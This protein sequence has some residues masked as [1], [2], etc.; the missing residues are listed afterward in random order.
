MELQSLE[1]KVSALFESKFNQQPQLI[2]SAPG[3]INIIGEHTDYNLGLSMPAAINRWV[4]V[5]FAWRNDNIVKVASESY[6]NEMVYTIGQSFTPSDSW[7]KF[8]YG[9]LEIFQRTNKMDKGFNAFVWGNVPLGAGVSSS[10]A[11]EVSFMNLLRM[12]YKSP[13]TDV[14]A[15]KNCQKIEHEYIGV[16]SGLLDQYASL[17]SKA[18]KLMKLDFNSLTHEYSDADM[19]NWCWV[20]ANTK[21]K[22]ELSGSKYTERVNETQEGLKWLTTNNPKIKGFRDITINDVETIQNPVVK[23]RL[24]HFVLENA[25]VDL[26]AKAFAA[27]NIQEVGRILYEGHTSLQV[28]YEVS[29]D[30]LDYLV[31]LAKKF[32]GCAGARMMGG[33]FGGCTINLLKK[34]KLADFSTYILSNYKQKF[35]IDSEIYAFDVVD[36]A[37][38][39]PTT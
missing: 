20:L 9:A 21:V 2:S 38:C 10:A 31:E 35:N 15:V 4:I 27:K 3:R 8:I 7:M 24:K 32:D 29:C 6:N 30:E 26:L 12:A 33:G 37:A 1:K 16:K 5:C 11:V 28:D 18:G 36:G 23:K 34:E 39:K 17:F 25:R 13:M 14:E 22:R 19:G